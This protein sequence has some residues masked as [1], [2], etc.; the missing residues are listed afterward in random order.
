M[1]KFEMFSTKHASNDLYEYLFAFH[2][3]V[4]YLLML[5]AHKMCI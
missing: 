5:K 4:R 2:D 3:N 1:I